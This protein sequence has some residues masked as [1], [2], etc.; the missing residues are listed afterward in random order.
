M[1][2]AAARLRPWVTL[3]GWLTL[4]ALVLLYPVFPHWFDRYQFFPF[5]FGLVF[6]GLPHGAMDHLV[7]PHL[8]R[9][10]LTPVFLVRFILG[11]LVLVLL[12]LG[13]WRAAPGAALA[14]FLLMSWL[15]WGEGDAYFLRVFGGRAAPTSAASLGRSW[16]VRGALPILLPPLAFPA[17]FQNFTRGVLQWYAPAASV[18][19]ITPHVQAAGVA[20]ILGIVLLSLVVSWVEN[21]PARR[22]AF[23]MD[24]GE[25]ALL[26]AV[27]WR[28]PPILAVGVYFCVWHSWRHIARLMLADPKS[29]MLIA[30]GRVGR[31]VWRTALQSLPMTWGALALLGGLYVTRAH[32]AASA[33]DFVYLYLSL[34]AALTFPHFL[35]VL[36]MDKRQGVWATARQETDL[37]PVSPPRAAG[38]VPEASA[39]RRRRPPAAP[40]GRR[41]L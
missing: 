38:T 36:W 17:H 40:P 13:L 18:G 22:A 8:T 34:I 23:W 25:D 14:L 16:A 26:L 15:H 28:V 39:R 10:P 30:D 4:A 41:L 29:E 21:G 37:K 11:Y 7:I 19:R 32:R 1:D 3:P 9:R 33:G 20:V 5:L 6:L 27:F 2:A 31:S 12:Y 24:A 35:L